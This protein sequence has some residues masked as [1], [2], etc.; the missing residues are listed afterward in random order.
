MQLSVM[1]APGI[2]AE[3]PLAGSTAVV[4]DVLRATTSMV[5]ALDAG[6]RAIYPVLAP[7][8]A[9]R[10]QAKLGGE[11]LLGGERGGL[12]IS[13]FDLGNSPREYTAKAVGGQLLAMTTTNGTAALAAAHGAGASPVYVAS[14]RNAPAAAR[15]LL[16]EARPTVIVCAGTDGRVSLDDVISAGAIVSA[17]L[18]SPADVT[19]TDT[20]R[21]ALAAYR[22]V[23]R[24]LVRGLRETSHG[25][26]MVEL[27]F[28]ADIV[29]AAAI[30]TSNVVGQYDGLMIVPAGHVL[31]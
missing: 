13:G 26:R 7:D 20:A 10:L 3:L 25:Q 16:R 27:G 23:H 24:D 14:L 29:H 8:D 28:E 30:G 6:V 31:R 19:L 2:P 17:C 15:R 18:D 4:I 22:D 5:A 9:W 12:K 11:M 21:L 1:L